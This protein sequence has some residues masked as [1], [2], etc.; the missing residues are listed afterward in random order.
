MSDAQIRYF[1]AIAGSPLRQDAMAASQFLPVDVG[2]PPREGYIRTMAVFVPTTE[3]IS[4]ADI[5]AF[6]KAM[7]EAGHD[8]SYARYPNGYKFDILPNFNGD[9]PV[10]PTPDALRQAYGATMERFGAPTV[11][12]HDFK[13]VYTP[14]DEYSAARIELLEEMK[15]DFIAKARAAKIPPGRAAKLAERA[16]DPKTKP[17]SVPAGLSGRGRKAWDSYRARLGALTDAE[18]GFQALA[19]RVANSHA[20]FAE[21]AT[22]RMERARKRAEKVE[23][24]ARG[25]YVGRPVD[26]SDD[27]LHE[28]LM[29]TVA[30]PMAQRFAMGGA[31][32]PAAVEPRINALTQRRGALSRGH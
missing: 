15:N 26:Q 31:V 6:S 19:E 23:K 16:A 8:L 21:K 4:P 10:G 2:A 1:N 20:T 13:S 30:P 7:S 9:A 12:E 11:L 32:F 3:Q 17:G 25:G 28:Y 22:K 18:Q 24:K 5:R 29:A 27:A 14:S